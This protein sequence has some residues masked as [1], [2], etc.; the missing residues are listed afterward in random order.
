MK[1]IHLKK[2]DEKLVQMY[3]GSVLKACTWT[4]GWQRSCVVKVHLGAGSLINGVTPNE[5]SSSV[6]MK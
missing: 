1:Q 3:A 5:A 4:G 2:I 6:R